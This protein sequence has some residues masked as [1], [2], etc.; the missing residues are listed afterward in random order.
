MQG[1]V[2][3]IGYRGQRQQPPTTDTGAADGDVPSGQVGFLIA[4]PIDN[5][6]QRG[7]LLVSLG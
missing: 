1:V 4:G 3:A 5:H 6:V 2:G 7:D